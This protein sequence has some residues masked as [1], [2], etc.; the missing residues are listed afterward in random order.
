MISSHRPRVSTLRPRIGS[1]RVG[2]LRPRDSSLRP[3]VS[4][5][6]PPSHKISVLWLAL[7]DLE[8]ASSDLP[9]IKLVSYG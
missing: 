4:T 8:L 3:R 1:L 2:T 9:Y 5:L 7:L 6:R